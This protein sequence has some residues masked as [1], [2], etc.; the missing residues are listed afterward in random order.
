M[1]E[2]STTTTTAPA[3]KTFDTKKIIA[4]VVS[5]VVLFVI[6]WVAAKAWKK[7]AEA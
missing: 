7:G 6:V 1:A 3:E 5:L 2:T 4:F